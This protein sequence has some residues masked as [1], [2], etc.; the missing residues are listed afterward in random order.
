MLGGL[1]IS[2]L[3]Q[4]QADFRRAF[5]GKCKEG[6]T[7]FR[8]SRLP[9][10]FGQWSRFSCHAAK[11]PRRDI[12]PPAARKPIRG[13]AA[14]SLGFP[15]R[16]GLMSL[17]PA[18]PRF[19][20]HAAKRS[21]RSVA[22]A[23]AQAKPGPAARA[24]GFCLRS[25]PSSL[26]ARFSALLLSRCEASATGHK[27]SGCEETHPGACGPLLG[28]SSPLRPY[29]PAPGFS[30][31]LL[32]RCEAVRTLGRFRCGSGKTRSRCAGPGLLPSLRSKLPRC[33]LLRAS[34]RNSRRLCRGRPA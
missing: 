16:S 18:S 15:L 19:S 27:S 33:P 9:A 31:L 21:G 34:F 17:L 25:A 26:A 13:P 4:K 12:S 5:G 3:R 23:A 11:P 7:G 29:V 22:F 1:E 14:P 32:S 28:L 24:L 30:A 10:A 8:P 20:C 2:P 6:G